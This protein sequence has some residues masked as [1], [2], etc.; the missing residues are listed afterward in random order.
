MASAKHV[1]RIRRRAV[2]RP[3]D[4][5]AATFARAYLSGAS[6]RAKNQWH[7]DRRFGVWHFG[8]VL[9]RAGL[10]DIG[11]DFFR[12][13]VETDQ[14]RPNTAGPQ[15]GPG[16]ADFVDSR[17]PGFRRLAD[18]RDVP[19]WAEELPVVIQ[20]DLEFSAGSVFNG[21]QI[22][23]TQRNEIPIDS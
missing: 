20:N 7:G 19:A 14:P 17:L 16:R 5:T 1:S 23:Q 18:E 2:S 21:P 22:D 10:L 4:G 8:N 6:P 9:L 3:D 11:A 12:P 15:P 13:G